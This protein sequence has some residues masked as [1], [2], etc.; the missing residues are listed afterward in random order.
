MELEETVYC[1]PINY[2]IRIC[3]NDP[4]TMFLGEILYPLTK[5]ML[6]YSD[7][8]LAI[9]VGKNNQYD[10][11]MKHIDIWYHL[12]REAKS[13]GTLDLRYC[14]TQEMSADIFTKALLIKTFEKLHALLGI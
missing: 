7:N 2:R 5:P 10:A 14:P 12:I 13:S 9:A 8:Q 1:F 3:C 6:I 11:R 4:C